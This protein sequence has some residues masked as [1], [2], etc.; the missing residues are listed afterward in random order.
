VSKW[1]TWNYG[2][3]SQGDGVQSAI[4]LQLLNY[5][6]VNLTL[7][8]SWATL[9][10]RLTRGGPTM[11]RPGIEGLNASL[12]S[13]PRRRFGGNAYFTAQRRD[14]G[15]WT[16]ALGGQLTF[17]PWAALTL[18]AAPAFLRVRNQAQ[19]LATVAD[20]AASTTFGARYVFGGLEQT[21]FAMPLR[22]N[23]VLSPKLSLQLYAQTLLSTGAYDAIKELQAPRSYA[24]VPFSG[25]I[26][27]PDFNVKALRANAV[28]R[29]EF[30]LGSTAYF[31]WT[32]RR[33]DQRHPGDFSLGRDT[34]DLFRSSSDDV[35]M[36]KVAWWLGR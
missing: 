30:R 31:V 1:W 3:E 13:D 27:N 35:L 26:A 19:Y 7:Q 29:W 11:I 4:N 12:V 36:V 2:G 17:R 14:F 23:L 24:F 20:P 25:D 6:R 34:R 15:N 22:V 8:R 28:V 18:Q 32:Q 21:E 10:D 16:R 33:Q 9:D 5:W